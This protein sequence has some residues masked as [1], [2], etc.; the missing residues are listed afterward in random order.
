[1]KTKTINQLITKDITIGDIVTKYPGT[2][3]VMLNHGLHCIGCHVNPMETIE[4]GALS[5]GMNK[6]EFES[7]LSE[8]NKTASDPKSNMIKKSCCSGSCGCG[9]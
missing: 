4:Q 1:M 2:V 9:H 6:K 5:H 3:E 7:M 8:I